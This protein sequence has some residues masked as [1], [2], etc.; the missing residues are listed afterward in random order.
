MQERA[1]AKRVGVWLI[2]C[3]ASQVENTPLIEAAKEDD[4][5]VVKKLLAWGADKQAHGDVRVKGGCG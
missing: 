4:V 5:A 1:C 3:R 2:C